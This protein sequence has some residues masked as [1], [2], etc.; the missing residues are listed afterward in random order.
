MSDRLIIRKYKNRRF[1]D[2]ERSCHLTR[3]DLL[4]LVL[5]GRDVQVQEAGSDRDVTVVTLLQILL[6]RNGDV[7]NDSI[8]A[9]LVHLL[10]R[11]NEMV[12]KSFFGQF[13]PLASQFLKGTIP[14]AFPQQGGSGL[15]SPAAFM[16]PWMSLWGQQPEARG[17]ET[18][19]ENEAQGEISNLKKKLRD[20]AEEIDRLDKKK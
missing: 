4:D 17:V 11:S 5:E 8:P 16:N 14:T 20:L 3:D 6:S 10:V 13:F 9:E 19:P 15:M 18:E 7:L 1:Y 12:L 2:T